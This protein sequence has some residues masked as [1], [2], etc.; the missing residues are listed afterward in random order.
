MTDNVAALVMAAGLGTRMRSATPKHLHPLLGRRMV[1]WVIAAAR[2]TGAAPIV[3][4]ASPQTRD[5]FDGLEVAVQERPLGTGDAVRAAH[6][7]LG[8]TTGD[9]LVLPADTPLPTGDALRELLDTHRRERAAATVLSFEPPE[10]RQY[11]RDVRD[12][13]GRLARIVEASDAV[14]DELELREVNSSIYVFAADKLWPAL[15]RLQPKNAQGE[16]YLTDAVGALVAAGEAVAG[17]VAP[18][19]GEAGGINT[20]AELAAAAAALRPRINEQHMLAGVT[21]VDPQSTWIDAG[22]EIERDV[23]VH[24]FTVI[25][26]EVTIASGVEIGPFAYVR[27][28]TR[29]GEDA[30]IGTFVEVKKSSVGA[31][32]KI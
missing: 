5:G 18:G 25:R 27:P 21:I 24:P 13:N 29:L 15:E 3:V 16:L 8:S 1:D 22:V 10:P 23:T 11:G 14:P 28:G 7:K 19:P 30:K 6:T 31:R 20:R 2:D 32:A 17:H 12:G 4:V 26:G 9:V